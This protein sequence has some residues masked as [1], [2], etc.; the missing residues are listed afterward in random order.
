[1]DILSFSLHFSDYVLLIL[2]RFLIVILHGRA[3]N[4]AYMDSYI[5]CLLL[6]FLQILQIAAT[7]HKVEDKTKPSQEKLKKQYTKVLPGLR[8]AIDGEH[9]HFHYTVV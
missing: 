4:S 9:C 1:M 7:M 5:R 2:L 8:D 3:T 6:L